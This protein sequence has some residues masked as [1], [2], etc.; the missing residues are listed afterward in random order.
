MSYF[1]I[2]RC[3]TGIIC[4]NCMKLVKTVYQP[5]RYNVNI[6]VCFNCLTDTPREKEVKSDEK[7]ITMDHSIKI[8]K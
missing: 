6:N 3:E 4:F 8:V 5:Y 7:G 2:T 1:S